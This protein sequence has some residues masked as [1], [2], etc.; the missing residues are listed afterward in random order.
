MEGFIKLHHKMLE[1]GWYDDPN[2]C[3]L[4]IHCL[5]KAN[6]KACEWHGHKLKPGEFVT[7]IHSLSEET[8]LSARQVRTALDHLQKTGEVTNKSFT[9]FRIITVKNWDQYQVI[10]KQPTNNRQTTDKQPTTVEE[11]KNKR[12]K[13][14]F[15]DFKQRKYDFEELERNMQ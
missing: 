12:K 4:F 9:K 13:D 3:R 10:D 15:S 8:G 1:W 14:K 5:L 7:S 2:T 6:W 11:Y